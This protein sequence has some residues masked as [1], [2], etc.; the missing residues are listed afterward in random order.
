MIS[1]LDHPYQMDESISK[2]R[3][4]GV[5]CH[6]YSFS[7]RNSCKQTVKTLIT[8]RVL[9]SGSALFAKV[10]KMGRKA[11]TT[12]VSIKRIAFKKLVT[13]R[14]ASRP[15][16]Y[17]DDSDHLRKNMFILCNRSACRA[18]TAA[19]SHRLLEFGIHFQIISSF[20]LKTQKIL[21][22]SFL[23][24]WGLGTNFPTADLGE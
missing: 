24:L 6:F 23:L 14:L 7:N 20:L 9:W 16:C 8:H 13:A 22:L 21:L 2:F 19:S 12:S 10:P 1:G 15:I 18:S 4:P 3:G 5:C 17:Q 11:L